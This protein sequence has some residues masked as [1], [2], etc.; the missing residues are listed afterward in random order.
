M[1]GG[2]SLGPVVP[3]YQNPTVKAHEKLGHAERIRR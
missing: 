2:S 3:R 1:D